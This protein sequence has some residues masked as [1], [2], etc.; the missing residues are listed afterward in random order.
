M[1]IGIITLL[2]MLVS[3]YGCWRWQAQRRLLRV[4]IHGQMYFWSAYI[5][6]SALLM[7]LNVYRI[8]YAAMGTLTVTMA[9]FVISCISFGKKQPLRT[10]QKIWDRGD[11]LVL[12][13][14][15]LT[16]VGIH[17]KNELM[18]MCQDEG[19]Y[20]TIAISYMA[21]NNG[22]QKTLD[23]YDLLGEEDQNAFLEKLN[24]VIS[25]G[26]HGYYLFRGD[27]L[28]RNLQ[29][30]YSDTSGYYHGIPTYAAAMALWGSI[31]GWKHMMGVQSAFYMLALLLFYELIRGTSLSIGKK[32]LLTAIYGLSPIMLW[33]GKSSLTEL[34]L[35]CLINWFLYEL[36]SGKKEKFRAMRIAL[37]IIVFAFVHLTIYTLMPMIIVCLLI[38]FWDERNVV[39]LKAGLYISAGYLGGIL[40]TAW[41]YTEY[42]YLNV[43][44]LTGLAILNDGNVLAILCLC[45]GISAALFIALYL[46]RGKLPR[47]SM[48]L[49]VWGLRIV[50]GMLM[51][52]GIWLAARTVM[53][54]GQW[55]KLT[56]LSY[57]LLTG[58]LVLPVV[59]G[60]LMGKPEMYCHD[61]KN[62][63]ITWFFLYC[64]LF[65]AILFR[66][67]IINHYY[68]D[69]YLAPFLVGVIL[70]LGIT[71]E[72]VQA[73]RAGKYLTILCGLAALG[74][75][76]V[77][78]GYIIKHRDDT[79]IEWTILEEICKNLSEDD[80]LILEDNQMISCFFTI[81][82]LTGAYCYPVFGKDIWDTVDRLM[83]LNRNIYVLGTA[84]ELLQA[85]DIAGVWEVSYY[86][87]AGV[88]NS[89]PV[90]PLKMVDSSFV[91]MWRLIRCPTPY[92]NQGSA[93]ET[94][95]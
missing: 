33:L 2:A 24:S 48:I 12:L 65:Y 87:Y 47:P 13:L 29:K 39:F 74:Y 76:V 57:L 27:Y 71:L 22:N 41:C 62:V 49:Q 81:R 28:P 58:I 72:Q 61:R 73:K 38:Y 60:F 75:F 59:L 95:R 68:G 5:L 15:I 9:G 31:F 91:E 56:L 44:F 55:E 83:P 23:E 89:G 34:L 92:Y 86:E 80:I 36:L 6:T 37:P 10:E 93:D 64:V 16:A 8:G 53:A 82:D 3:S 51:L 77:H 79:R 19:V 84:E 88:E 63:F 42:F 14:C 7:W 25:Q 70:M 45:G 17:D 90:D 32:I 40:F 69:R 1:G 43:R 30:Q 21:G 46:Y 67:G 94:G 85:S 11:T 35:A 78:D 26:M 54:G 18:G 4:C 52:A 20:Q 66:K 50:V